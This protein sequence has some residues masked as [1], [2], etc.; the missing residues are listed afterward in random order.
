MS[1]EHTGAGESGAV[2]GAGCRDVR[3][4]G[5]SRQGLCET[6]WGGQEGITKEATLREEGEFVRWTQWKGM[7]ARGI[8][9]CRGAETWKHLM[10]SGRARG[11]EW[12]ESGVCEMRV[13]RLASGVPFPCYPISTVYGT[14]LHV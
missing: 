4:L 14:S 6:A 7:P 11:L 2:G 13:E 9:T 10:C 8:S 12:L 5:S 3:E 1:E